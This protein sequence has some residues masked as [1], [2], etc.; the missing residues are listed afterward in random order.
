MAIVKE[1]NHSNFGKVRVALSSDEKMVYCLQDLCKL[2]GLNMQNVIAL[3]GN[4]KIIYLEYIVK[5]NKT[6][7]FY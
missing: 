2:L 6:K 1:V 4:D 5:K 7:S 3:L